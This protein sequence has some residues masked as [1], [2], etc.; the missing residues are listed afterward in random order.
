MGTNV[1]AECDAELLGRELTTVAALE[2]VLVVEVDAAAEDDFAAADA[3][4][5][6]LFKKH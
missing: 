1:V 6:W 3:A 5:F 4:D 2:I